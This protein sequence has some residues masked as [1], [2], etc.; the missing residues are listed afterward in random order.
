MYTSTNGAFELALMTNSFL[1]MLVTG[2]LSQE[3]QQIRIKAIMLRG[4]KRCSFF[5]FLNLILQGKWKAV[6]L[7][8]LEVWKAGLG[9]LRKIVSLGLKSLLHLT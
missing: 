3:T 4:N 7:V 2:L 9:I 6:D 5:I 1:L 8:K